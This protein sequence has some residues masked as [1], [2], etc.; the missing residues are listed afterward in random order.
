MDDCEIRQEHENMRALLGRIEMLLEEGDPASGPEL[1]EL[2]Q[3][4]CDSFDGAAHPGNSRALRECVAHGNVEVIA[5]LVW[6]L[7]PHCRDSL[8]FAI[9]MLA[10]LMDVAEWDGLCIIDE[11]PK[12]KDPQYS[13]VDVGLVNSLLLAGSVARETMQHLR[14]IVAEADR[15]LILAS[16]V[17]LDSWLDGCDPRI[18]DIADTPFPDLDRRFSGADSTIREVVKRIYQRIEY[19][20]RRRESRQPRE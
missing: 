4:V 17:Y 7:H 18:F 20:R 19:S 2:A 15:D 1:N 10:R 6:Y 16:L 13:V 5:H 8:E 11:I 12:L 14:D 3:A 9:R